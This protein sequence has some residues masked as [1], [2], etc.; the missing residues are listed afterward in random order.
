[1]SEGL[2]QFFLLPD[3]VATF[4]A[5]GYWLMNDPEQTGIHGVVPV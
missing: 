1:M 5:D 3:S 4:L 2:C